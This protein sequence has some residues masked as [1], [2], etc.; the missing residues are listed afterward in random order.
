MKETYKGYTINIV[1]DENAEDPREWDNLS[2]FALFHRRHNVPNETILNER[3]FETWGELKRAIIREYNPAVMVPVSAY[4]HSGLF[5]R[6]TAAPFGQHSD[7]DWGL[8]GFAFITHKQ[9]QD[10]YGWKRITA[11]RRARLHEL[12]TSDVETYA[13]Y[14]SGDAWVLSIEDENGEHMDSMGGFFGYYI[15][16]HE[17]EVIIDQILE[18]SLDPVQLV[19][20]KEL[21]PE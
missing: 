21:Y 20:D 12:V 19:A 2:T 16:L 13:Q 10:E 14:V 7:W 4:D 1:Q 15:A 3:D 18:E 6:A 11:S 8:L 9:A 17:A 5:I